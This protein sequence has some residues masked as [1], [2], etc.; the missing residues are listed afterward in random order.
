MQKRYKYQEIAL[1]LERKIASGELLSG[2]QFP[3][4][5]ILA[6]EYGVNH[7]TLRKAMDILVRGG[8]ITRSPGRGTF[9]ADRPGDKKSVN[10]TILYAGDMD[11]HFFKELYFSLLDSAQDSGYVLTSFNPSSIKDN[12]KMM[13]ELKFRMEGVECVI[14]NKNSLGPV[15]SIVGRNGKTIIVVDIYD[16]GKENVQCYS[17]SSNVFMATKLAT[18]YLLELGHRQISFIGAPDLGSPN[19]EFRI[20]ARSR[21]SYQ[22]YA[23]SFFMRSLP[24][25]PELAVGPL[26]E[27]VAECEA[28]LYS[29]LKTLKKWPTAFVCEGDFRAAALIRAAGRLRKMVP[30][31]FSIV[32]TGNTPWAEMT[33]PS[34]TSVYMGEKEMAQI[35]VL[36]A[37]Q[38]PRMDGSF[39]QVSP[40]LIIRES[41]RALK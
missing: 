15:V 34:L 27:G 11:S 3:P 5:N 16:D 40:K 38:E 7:L 35:A 30:D 6:R 8:K 2:I 9:I 12:K 32:G 37:N 18:E 28:S 31:D 39:V 23:A 22:G 10:K 14:C 36:L 25:P 26:G 17:I 20:P 21:R 13:S 33:S 24:L 19:T 29:W 41:T 4:E 1:S